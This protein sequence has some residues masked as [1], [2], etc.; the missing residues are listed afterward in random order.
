MFVAAPCRAQP[1]FAPD[2]KPFIITIDFSKHA[3]GTVLSQ[4]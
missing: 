1:D 4:E 3:V 2:A